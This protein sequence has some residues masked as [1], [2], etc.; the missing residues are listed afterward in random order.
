M[1]FVCYLRLSYG[2]YLATSS[3]LETSVELT[4]LHLLEMAIHR[5]N[6]LLSDMSRCLVIRKCL[7]L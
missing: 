7:P 3:D 5:D 1:I 4:N 6:F 2:S